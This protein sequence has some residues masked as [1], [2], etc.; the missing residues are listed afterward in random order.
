[1]KK[2]DSLGICLSDTLPHHPNDEELI[3]PAGLIPIKYFDIL[4]SL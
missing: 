1:M 3:A 4:L 2:P